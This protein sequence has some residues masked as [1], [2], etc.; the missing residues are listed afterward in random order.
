MLASP[1]DHGCTCVC[2]GTQGAA[3]STH[4]SFNV[5]HKVIGHQVVVPASGD[6]YGNR[7]SNYF[8]D[9]NSTI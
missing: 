9:F 3:G 8:E 6:G 2:P 4:L 1:L 7:D 5:S